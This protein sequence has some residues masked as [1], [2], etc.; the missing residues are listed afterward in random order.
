MG[1]GEARRVFVFMGLT[2]QAGQQGYEGNADEGDTAAR[3][4]LFHTLRFCLCVIK[5]Q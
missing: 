5:K 3:H 4:E 1:R 2:E